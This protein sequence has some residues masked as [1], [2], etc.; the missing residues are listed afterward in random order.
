MSHKEEQFSKASALTFVIS[1][2][3]QG[4]IQLEAASLLHIFVFQIGLLVLLRL[5]L[6]LEI[7]HVTQ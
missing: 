5:L 3:F 2:I 1:N 6:V 7:F 4:R